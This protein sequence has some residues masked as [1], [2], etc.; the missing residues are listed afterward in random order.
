M[1]EA[2]RRFVLLVGDLLVFIYWRRYEVVGREHVPASGGVIV[3]KNHL[4][5]ADP[6]MVQR[7]LPRYLVSMAKKEMIRAPIIG[8][9][10]RAWGAFPVRRGEAD[11]CALRSA[12]QIVMLQP[13]VGVSWR[14]I[15]A[16]PLPAAAKRPGRSARFYR[17]NGP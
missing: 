2:Y 8:I 15:R 1:R 11:V 14:P 16:I 6:P 12:C 17:P 5:N 3:V 13:W 10:V 4:N 7:A 9:L